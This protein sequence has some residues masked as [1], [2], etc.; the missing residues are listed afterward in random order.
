MNKE[1]YINELRSK[2]SGFD[3]ELVNEI[4]QDYEEHFTLGYAQGKSD[5]Q[6]IASLGTIEDLVKEIESSYQRNNKSDSMSFTVDL[7]S[8]NDMSDKLN[9]MT[10]DLTDKYNKKYGDK[11]SKFAMNTEKLSKTA[12]KYSKEFSEEF[13]KRFS[14][15]DFGNIDEMFDEI[16]KHFESQPAEPSLSF[17]EDSDGDVSYEVDSQ[18]RKIVVRN[19]LGTINVTHT[20]ETPQVE[21]HNYG[22][23]KDKLMWS[24]EPRIEEDTLILELVR[25]NLANFTRHTNSVD[26]EL[27]I[28]FDEIEAISFENC[29]SSDISVSDIKAKQLK[30]NVLSGDIAIDSVKVS[31]MKISTTS[32]E[33]EINDSYMDVFDTHTTSG[34]VN[35]NDCVIDTIRINSVSG[36]ITYTD[37]KLYRAGITS[38]SG[39][40]ELDTEGISKVGIESISGDIRAIIGS[41]GEAHVR[42]TS[43][44]ITLE[45]HNDN[46][47]FI[48]K[49]KSTSGDINID[50]G[51]TRMHELASGNYNFNSQDIKLVA[52]TVSGDIEISD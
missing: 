26:C 38:T 32:G 40:I 24:F 7:S 13:E 50:Y 17:D 1:Q 47:G 35:F 8:L 42:T 31:E 43:G 27:E 28:A 2:L 15:M 20:D 19:F 12:E 16:G 49:L 10:R 3:E 4:L 45:L 48:S 23:Q 36:N 6:I 29:C 25:N 44:D 5:E 46:A 18:V 51:D 34:D 37:G 41:Q 52:A 11:F 22:S 9:K 33:V 30:A 14:E 39:D 21:F